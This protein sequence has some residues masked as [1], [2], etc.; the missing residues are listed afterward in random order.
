MELIETEEQLRNA[1][2]G[3]RSRTIRKI[4]DNRTIEILKEICENNEI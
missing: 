3:V 4:S 2:I 1:L